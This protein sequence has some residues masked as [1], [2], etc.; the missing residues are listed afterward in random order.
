MRVSRWWKC[1]LQVATPGWKFKFPAGTTLD[2]HKD[3]DRQKFADMYMQGASQKGV[4][5]LALAAH[6]THE[7]IDVLKDAGAR[8]GIY[9]FPGVEITTGTGS[10][11]VHLLVI[12]DNSKTGRDFDL[13]LSSEL[14]FDSKTPRFTQ[15]KSGL[16]PCSSR[17][18]I[19][20]I[21]DCLPSDY[22]VIAPHALSENGIASGGTVD[23]DR[24]WTAINHS[25][26]VALDVGEGS[27]GSE[28]NKEAFN[29]LFR[30]RALTYFP[31]LK[32]LAFIDT[33]DAYCIDDIGSR[34]T[35]IRMAHP[36]LEALRQAFLDYEARIIRHTDARLAQYSDQD[37]NNVKHAWIS[38][39]EL[40]ELGNSREPLRVDFHPGLNVVI[41]ARGSGKSTIVASLR[42]LYSSSA[43]LPRKIKE[44]S[45]AFVSTVLSNSNLSGSHVEAT[46]QLSATCEWSADTGSVQW[47][48]DQ[49]VP[50]NF[51]VRVVNQKELFER[52]AFD[53]DDPLSASRSLLAFVDESLGLLKSERPSIGTWWQQFEDARRKWIEATLELKSLTEKLSQSASVHARIKSL[54]EQIKAFDSPE[55]A[56][57]RKA[58]QQRQS[59]R[60]QMEHTMQ[61]ALEWLDALTVSVDESVPSVEREF[62]WDNWSNDEDAEHDDVPSLRSSLKQILDDTAELVRS[63]VQKGT[64]SIQ[65]WHTNWEQTTWWRSW[66]EANSILDAYQ[67]NLIERGID[68]DSYQALKEQLGEERGMLNELADIKKREEKCSTQLEAAKSAL[69]ELLDARRKKRQQ[70]LDD[71]QQRSQRL[72][73]EVIQNS[74][75]FGWIKSVRELLGLRNDWFVEDIDVIG[76]WLCEGADEQRMYR[77]RLWRQSLVDNDYT[78]LTAQISLRRDW[79]K[80][81]QTMDP[82]VRARLGTELVED[83]VRISFLKQG[84]SGA[85]ESDW[86]DISEG[87][88]GQRTAAMLAFV[89]HHGSEPLVLDQP[90][91]DLDTE[92]ISDLV[93]RELRQSR[94][95]RQLI[96]VTHNANIPV[97]GDAEQIVVLENR[98][99]CIRL[100]S[101]D[102]VGG[103]ECHT[104]PIEIME[105]RRDVQAIM[106]GGIA[107]FMSREQK[108][109][110]E[111]LEAQPIS[112]FDLMHS[113]VKV[114]EPDSSEGAVASP[115][116]AV[117]TPELQLLDFSVDDLS[118]PADEE[119][120]VE[121]QEDEDEAAYEQCEDGEEAEEDEDEK[122]DD[123]EGE[124]DEEGGWNFNVTEFPTS[125]PELGLVSVGDPLHHNK[126]GKGTLLNII[127]GNGVPLLHVEFEN[128]GKRLLD[129]RFAKL[130]KL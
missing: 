37:P 34:F 21:L 96:V 57:A 87:S 20:E 100:R 23:G 22:L 65:T 70:L 17:K 128:A 41:G 28:N 79:L 97:N 99:D 121:A 110:S 86:Q 63:A 122:Q 109:R 11:G 49:Q 27:K 72:R 77:L 3:G 4:E 80:K 127:H 103:T 112:E 40:G 13:L 5:V 47:F 60:E 35:W 76:A 6:N 89:L 120:E 62:D 93:V 106:E 85:E 33:S 29:K 108:Y 7:W 114:E 56:S 123:E 67:K 42:Q 83:S 117:R 71:V 53:R 95:K 38:S 64:T 124:D 88:A 8:H 111:I 16:T 24:R 30:D 36:S 15:G 115:S 118:P 9:V 25:R 69:N 1:D 125:V 55:A 90:E 10:D 74:D 126:F 105:V 19:P 48:E 107:A 101:S 12:G 91:D 92:L 50:T 94:W 39:V 43:T 78:D 46:S 58:Y 129:P 113:S 26:L 32:N 119:E 44:E 68:P 61:Q 45:E 98:N 82:T 81:L 54:E 104:G 73:F 52:V 59:E 18:T 102:S 66:S 31:R 51:Q 75:A 14:G 130:V 2:F 116:S 84:C